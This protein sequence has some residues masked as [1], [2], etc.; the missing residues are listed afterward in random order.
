MRTR[1]L[2]PLLE[3]VATAGV[4][5]DLGCGDG[6]LLYALHSRGLITSALAV[7][8]AS[9]HVRTAEQVSPVIR[10]VVGDATASGLPDKC[11][12]A[13]IVSQVI[14]HLP[15][16]RL[17]APE[18]A[19]LIRPDGWWYVS[20]VI[21][22]DRGWW[23]YKVDGVRR[24]DPTHTREYSDA[25]ELE[26]VL[27]VPGLRRTATMVTPMRFPVADLAARALVLAGRMKPERLVTL[28]ER[29]AW[30]RTARRMT[31][32]VPGYYLVEVAGVANHTR[33]RT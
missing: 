6:A 7:D 30:L 15:N 24:L 17:L 27:E 25:R 13:V 10:G 26:E 9:E 20:S 8:L 4:I 1:E 12:D 23:F 22:T 32:R 3:A 19:R 28:Y 14:E 33:D 18:L 16:D 31:V 21:K 11:A 5:C 29:S 2:P